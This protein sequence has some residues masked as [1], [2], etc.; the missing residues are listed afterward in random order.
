MVQILFKILNLNK[1][2]N[3]G[4]KKN[5]IVRASPSQKKNGT[6][7]IVADDDHDSGYLMMN[8]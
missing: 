3:E 8:R 1:N 7:N 6:V 4:E 2:K 5:K